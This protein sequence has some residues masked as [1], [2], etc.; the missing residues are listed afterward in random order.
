M[1]KVFEKDPRLPKTAVEEALDNI[2]LIK[3]GSKNEKELR[4]IDSSKP[5]QASKNT[6]LLREKVLS[7]LQPFFEKY[8][9]KV[10]TIIGESDSIAEEEK[11]GVNSTISI[12][13]EEG[14]TNCDLIY[15]SGKSSIGNQKLNEE[16]LE[17]LY[18]DPGEP[19]SFIAPD[20]DIVNDLGSISGLGLLYSIKA[21]IKG[22]QY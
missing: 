17:E 3:W 7:A 14:A 13:M 11:P 15:N 6:S 5:R 12:F 10:I 21:K 2:D 16:L 22:N 18:K 8:P 20:R 1:D 19:D 4:T 9:R